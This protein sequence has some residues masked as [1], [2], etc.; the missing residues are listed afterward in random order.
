MLCG[1]LRVSYFGCHHDSRQSVYKQQHRV[2]EKLLFSKLSHQPETKDGIS[3]SS[4]AG[5]N[6]SSPAHGS[7]RALRH[8]EIT[9]SK[10]ALPQTDFGVL[11]TEYS[12]IY[13][14]PYV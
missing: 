13:C 8:G 10:M 6:S 4:Y 1:L 12:I 5:S 7:A 2:K 14:T 11:Y 9:D 3:S